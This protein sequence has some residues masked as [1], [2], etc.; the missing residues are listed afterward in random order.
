MKKTVQKLSKMKGK[1]YK[2]L[3]C[4]I[5]VGGADGTRTGFAILIGKN[6]TE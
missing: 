4:K 6:E 2:L 1:I 3:F 5:N